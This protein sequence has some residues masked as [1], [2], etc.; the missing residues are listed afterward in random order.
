[1][2]IFLYAKVRV[3]EQ[4]GLYFYLVFHFLHTHTYTSP[5]IHKSLCEVGFV[6]LFLK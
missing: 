2:V 6:L 5:L 3:L 1:M 4:S